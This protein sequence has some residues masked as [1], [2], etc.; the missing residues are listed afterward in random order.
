MK[1][2]NVENK[3]ENNEN[4][5]EDNNKKS[6]NDL[7]L[8]KMN[9]K[10]NKRY[11]YRD[12]LLLND[13]DLFYKTGRIPYVFFS[14]LLCT[15]LVTIII[16]TQNENLN[17]LM[18]QARA[19]QSSF[20]LQDDTSTP[21][22]DYPRNYYYTKLETFS[23][24]L[25]KL[26]NNIYNI[27]STIDFDINFE[28]QDN[29]KMY[30]KF[31]RNSNYDEYNYPYF[32][33]IHKD[34]NPLLNY[35]D[36]D[37]SKIRAFLSKVDELS[38]QLK[39][40]YDR[41]DYDVCQ[42][43]NLNLVFDTSKISYIKYQPKF[44]Y[45]NCD[46]TF[47]T[48]K[49]GLKESFSIFS[50]LLILSAVIEEFFI[51]KKILSIIKIV[52]YLKE[53]LSQED[54]L[55]DFSNEQLFLRTGENKWDLITNK[56]IF[57]L[58]P[59]WLFLFVLTGI[60]NTIG[61]I[62]FLFVPFLNQLNRIIFGFGAFFN[63]ISFA[64]YFHSNKKYIIFYRTLFKSMYEYKFLFTTFVVLF[65]GF[66]LLN[67]NIYCHSD[68]YYDG[69]QGTFVTVFAATLG[70]ILIDIWYSTFI[71]NPI[72]TLFLGFVMF[73]V[74]LGNHIRVM[75]TV[76]QES[77]QLANLETQ[78]SWLDKN[79]DY[80]DYLNQQFNINNVEEGEGST[81]SGEKKKKDFIIDDAW[82]RAVLNLDDM[83]KLETIDLNNLKVKGLNI[84][85]VVKYLKKLRKN[86]R[87]K[88]ISKEIYQEILE[89]DGNTEMEKL[90]G[91]NKQIGRAFK[92]IEKMFYKMFLHIQ[93]DNYYNNKE[94]FI[95]ICQQSLEKLDRF[96]Q[97]VLLD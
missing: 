15:V 38:I 22:L 42:L 58:F 55:E 86:N 78:K 85:A 9:S 82:M 24:N 34:E 71:Y 43:I 33:E 11:D 84:E 30:T 61:G 45:T 31:R 8:V 17:K 7:L 10:N 36:G 23:D 18:Q 90:D 64:Y 81:G 29:I 74:F 80:K 57:S 62:S 48:I 88:K 52:F 35:F 75:F 92:N 5:N 79:F 91:K 83:N 16:L 89:E 70:D 59:K 12:I 46:F 87:N 3:E 44:E 32:F 26:I 47:G 53:N 1:E 56:D 77:F 97:E 63:W 65:T 20:Y 40:K 39:Y 94:K 13:L 49:S 60:L 67:L 95:E 41:L 69:F 28:N 27:N 93:K 19:I 73:V 51:L 50:L 76:T 66:C 37:Y 2:N 72:V 68:K 54:I 96:K 6:E 25:M 14:H 21:T 4:D